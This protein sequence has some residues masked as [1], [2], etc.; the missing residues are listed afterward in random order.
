MNTDDAIANKIIE[1]AVKTLN[2]SILVD[3]VC[4][5]GRPNSIEIL[6]ITRKGEKQKNKKND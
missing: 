3:D 6:E 4:R 1:W 2:K 5:N